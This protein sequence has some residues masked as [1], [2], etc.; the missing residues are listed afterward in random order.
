[1]VWARWGCARGTSQPW[2]PLLSPL[3]GD[4]R[5]QGHNGGDTASAGP[6]NSPTLS[7]FQQGLGW[8]DPKHSHP[9]GCPPMPPAW[10]GPGCPLVFPTW[11]SNEVSSPCPNPAIP[12]DGPSRS[13]PL[14][15]L[16]VPLC[17]KPV[18]AL[19]CLLVSPA[20]P[21]TAV[22][23]LCPQ[24]GHPLGCPLHVPNL[25]RPWGIPTVTV[26]L[27]SSTQPSSLCPQ[28]GHPFRHPL[29]SPTCPSLGWPHSVPNLSYSLGCPHPGH[30]FSCPQPGH[31][32]RC[33]QPVCLLRCPHR[34]LSLFIPWSVPTPSIP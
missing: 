24:P 7:G 28:H 25:A 16:R 27:M 18:H 20:C 26:L 8:Q 2:S 29:M 10:P 3:P 31:A 32:L 21:T 1:M 11:T 17:P 9:L 14:H 5:C 23:P 30:P 33:P 6:G 15:P 4:T 34:V 19:G 12:W 22:S 13:Q